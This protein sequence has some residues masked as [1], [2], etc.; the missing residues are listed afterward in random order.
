MRYGDVI[1]LY[2]VSHYSK[3]KE[4]GY[5]GYYCKGKSKRGVR[6]HKAG[7]FVAIPP[8]DEKNKHQFMASCFQ[9]ADP[10]G[11]SVIAQGKEEHSVCVGGGRKGEG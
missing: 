8:F 9:V 4:G 10:T 5:V 3:G 2:C 7:P 11:E 6:G 1:R